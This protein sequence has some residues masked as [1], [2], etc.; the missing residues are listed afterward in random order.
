MATTQ[1]AASMPTL[2]M[3]AAEVADI[4]ARFGG[5]DAYLEWLRSA[6]VARLERQAVTEAREQVNTA[7]RERVD[8]ALSDLP[9][10]LTEPGQA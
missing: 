1:N 8:Q 5:E 2:T 6:I 3:T 7:I 9:P 4:V 10:A